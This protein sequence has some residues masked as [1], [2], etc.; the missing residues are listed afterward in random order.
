MKQ[1]ANFFIFLEM[2]LIF[3]I[4]ILWTFYPESAMTQFQVSTESITGINALNCD[5]AGIVLAIGLFLLLYFIQGTRWLYPATI[6]AFAVL[7]GRV[8]SLFID[9][10]SQVALLATF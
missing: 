8:I 5:M 6:A 10:V 9:G 1:L 2:C 3:G 4:W 7:F